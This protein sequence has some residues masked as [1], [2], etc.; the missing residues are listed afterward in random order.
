MNFI[1]APSSR[2]RKP[3]PKHTQSCCF[4]T[5]ILDLPQK[6]PNLGSGRRAPSH[7]KS[8]ESERGKRESESGKRESDSDSENDDN[9]E[10]ARGR[11]TFCLDFGLVNKQI[12]TP[13]VS[14]DEPEATLSV[15]SFNS[16]SVLVAFHALLK[17]GQC[18]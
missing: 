5:A 6:I 16:T 9:Q 15:V 10:R 14:C 13:I 7:T 12:W 11:Q 3:V 2:A 17:N 8:G 4:T 18:R 1:L